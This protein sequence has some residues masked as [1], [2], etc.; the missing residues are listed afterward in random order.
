MAGQILINEGV[1]PDTPP[2]GYATIYVKTDGQFYTKDDAGNENDL[3]GAT[4]PTGPTGA[5]GATG[6]QGTQ[7]LYWLGAWSGATA[8]VI[9][10]AVVENGT[11]YICILGHTNQQ[12]PNASYWDTL[13]VKGADGVGTGDFSTNTAISAANEAVLFADTLG[14]TGARSKVTITPVATGSTLTIADG[15]TLTASNTVTLT[16]TDGSSFSVGTGG[17]AAVLGTASVQALNVSHHGGLTTAQIAVLG[18]A[19]VQALNVSHF[20]NLTTSQV[21]ILTTASVQALN[22]SHFG[23]LTTAD[24]AVLG[25]A[26]VQAL[27]VSHFG[28]LTTAQVA[29]LGTA[30]V[31]ALNVSHHGSL[32]TSQIAVLASANSFTATNTFKGLIDTVYTITD[33]AAFEID[34]ANGSVQ[35]VTLGASR[36]PAATNFAAGQSVLL[37][38]DDGSAYSV[39]WT[40]VAPVWTKVGGTGVAP[41][42]ATSGYTWVNLWK[43]GSTIYGSPGLAP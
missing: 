40:T 6:P 43:V 5:T 4:G 24:V 41:T 16:G 36:T 11:S 35:V 12:P 1:A 17:T 2:T 10:D 30:S 42:L 29:V 27:N 9:D 25:T 15:K 8:Y 13:A 37:G 19:S 32:T 22:V 7:G 3:V 21:A 14:K 18:T 28:N 34:P 26:S 33:G 31:Q 23:G 20:G 38:I 39:T